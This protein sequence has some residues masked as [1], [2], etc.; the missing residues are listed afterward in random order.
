M[1][2]AG[3]H[4]RTSSGNDTALHELSYS[5]RRIPGVTDNHVRDSIV[6]PASKFNLENAITG[7]LWVDPKR[8]LQ[9][10][11]GPR[12]VVEALYHRIR[13]DTRHT[14]VR[15]LWSAP[16]SSRSFERWG[17]RAIHVPMDES[18][19]GIVREHASRDEA[20][21]SATLPAVAPRV[22]HWL[23]VASLNPTLRL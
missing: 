13:R 9:V 22:R 16:L 11:E 21:L 14:D 8:F 20:E 1:V 6:L 19:E 23:Q 17:M 10:L 5:S 12:L 4:V 15:L 3:T 2:D 7:V 18:I